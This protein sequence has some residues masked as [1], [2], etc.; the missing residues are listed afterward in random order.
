[1]NRRPRDTTSKAW[2][3]VGS[4]PRAD[5]GAAV[6]LLVVAVFSIA[7]LAGRLPLLSQNGGDNGS[8]GDGPLRTP[9]PS[10]VVI[11]DPRSDV[12]GT[13]LYVKAGNIWLQ[14]GATAT[15][16]TSGGQDSMP[17]F[18]AD[19]QWIYFIR[20]VDEPGRWRIS[21]VPVRYQLATPTLMRIPR[22]GSAEP[23]GLLQGRITSG[24]YTW[25]YFLR[26]PVVSPDGS[27]IVVITDGPD[28]DK[29]DVVLKELDPATKKLTS[30]D[31]PEISPLGH[32]DPAWSPDGL[33]LLFVKNARDGSRGA[34][35]VMRYTFKSGK[36]VAVT[37]PGYT[38]PAWSPDGTLIA[39][40]R[41]TSFGTDIV[42]LDA[43]RGTE[44]LRVTANERSFD[45]VWSP[46]GD[47]IAYLS[48]DGGVT[49]L[50]LA[51]VRR[52]PTLSLE[53]E[54]LALTIAAG[55][56]AASRPDWWIPPESLPTAEPS[57]TSSPTSPPTAA[58]SVP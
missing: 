15:A 49:D 13:I 55:L 54:P 25:S 47:A 5:V 8:G 7:L 36:A 2:S 27:R 40:T 9:T 58:P 53:G 18:S 48:I 44:L 50:W 39:A 22:D 24:E 17:T 1:M 6:G 52:A 16:L 51:G 38:A 42:V 21:G 19:G 30:L 14:S 3:Y 32:Q 4:L 57:P 41:T 43:K 33:S 28:P 10:N 26:Q 23:E 31:A 45:P 11:V 56:D 37:G 20:T 29:S 35:I 34:P 46:A 12:L